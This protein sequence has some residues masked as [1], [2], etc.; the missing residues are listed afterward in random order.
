MGEYILDR[1]L[2]KYKD[3]VNS[4]KTYLEMAAR[5]GE[6]ILKNST[7]PPRYVT[8]ETIDMTKTS[9]KFNDLNDNISKYVF[10]KESVAVWLSTYKEGGYVV[11][12]LLETHIF[13][14]LKNDGYAGNILYVD[15][16]L[17]VDDYKKLFDK[18]S[19][20]LAP[21]PNYSLEVLYHQIYDA[22]YVFWDKFNLV[23]KNYDLS[24]L[25]EILSTRY[26]NCH[27]NMFL[28]AVVSSNA[29]EE[30]TTH[31]LYCNFSKPLLEVMNIGFTKDLHLEKL[32]I[33]EGE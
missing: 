24:K 12:R 6:I 5:K 2:H 3:E 33:K 28:M 17:L 32:P 7:I 1:I 13:N 19:D 4:D 22:N 23:D 18:N 29:P 14:A 27:S 31:D 9:K 20:T 10:D 26:N 25:Y 16:P 15:T 11:S 30:L 8:D 21:R